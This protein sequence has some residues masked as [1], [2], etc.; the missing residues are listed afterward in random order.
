M[1][2]TGRASV[3][4]GH[5]ALPVADRSATSSPDHV[6]SAALGAG[7]R[8]PVRLSAQRLL[9]VRLPRP[10]EPF[11][12]TGRRPVTAMSRRS[13]C[14]TAGRCSC[15]QRWQRADKSLRRWRV[16][17]VVDA[18]MPLPT[19]RPAARSL[20]GQREQKVYLELAARSPSR[21]PTPSPRAAH[22]DVPAEFPGD[23][24]TSRVRL[25]Q[26]RRDRPRPR[27]F[28]ASRPRRSAA[29]ASL[30]PPSDPDDAI[31]GTA[32]SALRLPR[33]CWPPPRRPG[34]RRHR[35]C[36][37]SC[38][39]SSRLR[40]GMVVASTPE[41]ARAAP[42]SSPPGATRSTAAVAVGLA[43]G[44]SDLASPVSAASSPC[45]CAWRTPRGGDRRS[46][47]CA[48]R[49]TEELQYLRDTGTAW[50]HK[51]VAATRR[52]RRSRPRRRALRHPAFP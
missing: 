23:P 37:P 50:G 26:R 11:Y 38:E 45:S 36:R 15:W 21:R 20:W 42:K 9:E 41:A 40:N 34:R 17:N 16:V 30:G 28:V 14:A 48:A 31:R 7:W 29:A 44:S 2:D 43:L 1:T 10:D 4:E 3:R 12:L 51:M 5:H 25:R 8:R 32:W 35:S 49:V 13:S 27:V 47:R 39:P 52:A 18:G 19:R 24:A 6:G 33:P 46:A 22:D